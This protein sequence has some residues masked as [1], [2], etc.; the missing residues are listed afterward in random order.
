MIAFGPSDRRH[1]LIVAELQLTWLGS[2]RAVTHV[3]RRIAQV[4]VHL[5]EDLRLE[6]GQNL[7]VFGR[8]CI[9]QVRGGTSVIGRPSLPSLRH[10]LD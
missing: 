4:F 2:S 8:V 7:L 5:V 1:H 10:V 9:S 6:A 3:R